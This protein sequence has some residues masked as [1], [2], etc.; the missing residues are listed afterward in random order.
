MLNTR[1]RSIN[2]SSSANTAREVAKM[3]SLDGERES[4]AMMDVPYKAIFAGL[5]V[6][7]LVLQFV[8]EDW[9]YFAMFAV[10]AIIALYFGSRQNGS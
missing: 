3:V 8:M 2:P 6:L 10:A 7:G 9:A 1:G 5:I 4:T